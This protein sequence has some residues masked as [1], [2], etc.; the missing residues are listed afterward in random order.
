MQLPLIVILGPTASGKTSYAIELARRVDGEVICADSRTVYRDMN[1]GTAKPTVEEQGAIPHWGLDL[2]EPDERFT[3]YDFQQYAKAKMVE[4]R[5]RN[6]VPMLV[7]GSGLYI[8]SAL[9]DYKFEEKA[10][11]EYEG[12]SNDELYKMLLEVDPNT[13]IHLNNRVRVINALNYYKANNR[14]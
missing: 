9:Y 2:V 6:H 13:N 7:G 12:V 5:S 1:I 8:R 4:I 14:I 3:L 10:N 11:D